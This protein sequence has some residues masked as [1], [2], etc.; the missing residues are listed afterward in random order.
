MKCYTRPMRRLLLISL[1]SWTAASAKALSDRELVQDRLSK[2][3]E[4]DRERDRALRREIRDLGGTKAVPL[5]VEALDSPDLLIR[6]NAIDLLQGF[7]ESSVAAVPK[8]IALL[9]SDREAP[10]S[11]RALKSIGSAAIGPLIAALSS[12]NPLQR[13]MAAEALKRQHPHWAPLEA[14]PALARMAEADADLEARCAAV[15]AIG[16]FQPDGERHLEVLIKALD[17]DVPPLR[18]CAVFSL[19]V[20]ETR[21]P[22]AVP[23]LLRAAESSDNE[24]RERALQVLSQIPDARA[25]RAAGANGRLKS[26][27]AFFYAPFLAPFF[28]GLGLVSVGVFIA[29][30]IFSF[31][32]LV[33]L[34]RARERTASFVCALAAGAYCDL[35]VISY[36]AMMA[37]SRFADHSSVPSLFALVSL[38]L[39]LSLG[40]LHAAVRGKK[41]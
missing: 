37:G 15:H 9:G 23:A 32:F 25:K 4:K 5:L 31:F 41:A 30:Q 6:A 13:K 18:R 38:A 27:R 11:A 14:L 20:L 3:T 24:L 28:A 21:S 26:V 10:G 7:Q 39:K 1:I 2:M 17:S 40:V 12:P 34:L 16:T 29:A 33:R 36:S 22:D 35:A 19:F 8:L